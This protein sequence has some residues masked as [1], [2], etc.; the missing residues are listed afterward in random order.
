[1]GIDTNAFAVGSEVLL[2]IEG[3]GLLVEVENGRG[4]CRIIGNIYNDY[5]HRWFDRVLN[6]AELASM[7][8]VFTDL[9]EAD[10]D[11]FNAMVVFAMQLQKEATEVLNMIF[12]GEV[13][14]AKARILASRKELGPLRLGLSGTLQKLYSLKG[15]F[16]EISGVA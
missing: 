2:K 5:L 1:L 11:V 14:E 6:A 3:G 13:N 12:A 15:E 9:N 16:I 4:H 8:K 10:C 7:R